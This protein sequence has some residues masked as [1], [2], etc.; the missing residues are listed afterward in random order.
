MSRED[1]RR[2]DKELNGEDALFQGG[3]TDVKII[4]ISITV[5][6]FFYLNFFFVIFFF[7]AEEREEL[8][9]EDRR[10]EQQQQQH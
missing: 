9:R 7:N 4:E 8:S 2:E 1:R 5:N 3:K 6:V 10:R